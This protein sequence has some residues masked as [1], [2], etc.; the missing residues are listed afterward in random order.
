MIQLHSRIKIQLNGPHFQPS[1]NSPIVAYTETKVEI[2]NNID[3]VNQTKPFARQE[4]D[5]RNQFNSIYKLLPFSTV[6]C[7]IWFP[8]PW[9]EQRRC[10]K[11]WSGISN[12]RTSYWKS[13]LLEFTKHKTRMI[14]SMSNFGFATEYIFDCNQTKF[15]SEYASTRNQLQTTAVFHSNYFV[16]IRM[17]V[18]IFYSLVSY[19]I[20]HICSIYFLYFSV[21]V[22]TIL[23]TF[24]LFSK[25][26]RTQFRLTN[27]LCK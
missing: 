8:V 22:A 26:T 4:V 23:T 21:I 27:Q 24:Q 16:S 12:I 18:C 17:C 10:L 6:K 25:H 19:P 5:F 11:I 15:Y 14:T 13:T 20:T 2:D 7:A 1:S 9:T 3:I